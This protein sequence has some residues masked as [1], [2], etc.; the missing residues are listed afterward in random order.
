MHIIL[1]TVFNL[2]EMH[3]VG[4]ALDDVDDSILFSINQINLQT[5]DINNNNENNHSQ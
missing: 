4:K 3:T 5:E 1:L 2:L